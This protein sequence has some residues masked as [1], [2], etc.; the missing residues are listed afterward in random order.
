MEL[1]KEIE[2]IK[3]RNRRVE[4]DKAWEISFTRKLFI[5][6]STYIV[7]GLWLVVIHD[8]TPWLKSLVPAAGYMLSTLSLPFV[9]RWWIDKHRKS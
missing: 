6:G 9:K 3:E 5:A 7:A 2:I 8:T 1:E 4:N